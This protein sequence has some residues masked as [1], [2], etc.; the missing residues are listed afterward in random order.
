MPKRYGH[1]GKGS[2][3]RWGKSGAKYYYTP[4]NA[5]SKKA[6]EKKADKQAA[7]AYAHGYK[8]NAM[9]QHYQIIV[10][11]L[12]PVVR[13]DTMQGRDWVVVP[14]VIMVEGVLNGNCGALYYSAEEM[15]KVPAIWN[16]KP[17]VVYHPENFAGTACVKEELEVR[18]IGM[19]MNTRFKDGK[20]LSEAWLD[21]TRIDIVDPRVGE[22]I[23]NQIILELSTGL[24]T[25]VVEQEGV[26]N[27]KDYVGIAVNFR[28]DHLAVLPDQTGASSVN[29][30]AGFLRLNAACVE[31]ELTHSDVR[32]QLQKLVTASVGSDAWVED[33]YEDRFVYGTDGRTYEQRYSDTNDKLALTGVPVEVIRKITYENVTNVKGIDMRK[34]KEL[35]DALI[36]HKGTQFGEDD[37]EALMALNEEVLEKA[38]PVEVE[39]EVKPE[40]KSKDDA[41][42]PKE[43]VAE[44]QKVTNVEEYIKNLP[45]EVAR[46]MRHGIATYNEQVDTIVK[47]IIANEN[48][49]FAE[50]YLRGKDLAELKGIAKLAARTTPIENEDARFDFSGQGRTVDNT[51]EEE[52]LELPTMNFAKA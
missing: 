25:D 48:N 20:L 14:M 7:A 30:G 35:V 47:E 36:T 23:K 42:P 41:T 33:V 32:D 1:D 18:G 17:V 19:M 45:P 34:K 43:P 50:D 9:R 5:S 16:H 44:T 38:I 51:T 37:R 2:Y 29:D 31:N 3:V 27:G 4:G 12:K 13:N 26:W 46:Q 22:A 21:P 24:Y 49:T 6:A 40:V 8:E 10:R 15:K 39:P 52:P 11:N 28:P